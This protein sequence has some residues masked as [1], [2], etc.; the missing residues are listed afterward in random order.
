MGSFLSTANVWKKEVQCCID[1][2]VL[3]EIIKEKKD[4]LFG[5]C[6]HFCY[7]YFNADLGIVGFARA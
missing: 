5:L 4:D 7:F 6:W 3:R 1:F 2:S